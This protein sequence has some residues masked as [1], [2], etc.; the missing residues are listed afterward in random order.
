[1][2]F[3]L[4]IALV[5]VATGCGFTPGA[6]S[7][8]LPG[9]GGDVDADPTIDSTV[10]SADAPIFV[11]A[12][13]CLGGGLATVC[14]QPLPSQPLVLSGTIDTT[15]SP[16][17]AV[18]M[19]GG[20]ETCVLAGTTVQVAALT[21]YTATGTRPLVIVATDSVDIAG[22][23]DVAS[24]RGQPAGAGAST[25][26]CAAPAT[27]PKNDTGGAGGGAGGSFGDVGGNGGTGDIN[28]NG[29]SA[30]NA[31][32][33]TPAAAIKPT[34]IRAGCPG[35]AGGNGGGNVGSPGTGGGAVYLIA[36]MQISVGGGIVASGGGGGGGGFDE[37]GGG[38]GGSGG[39]VGLDAPSVMV[40]G[41]LA[42][43][44][45]GGGEGSGITASGNPGAN[46][47]ANASRA[48]GGIGGDSEGGN[49]G[50]GSGGASTTGSNG[51]NENGGGGGGGGGAGI[52]YVRGTLSGGGVTSPAPTVN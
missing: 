36:G 30:G 5:S 12:L 32:G 3:A 22:T 50:Q 51:G 18:M 33:G 43:T 17:C 37:S 21:T 13:A 44:G 11:D 14:L 16:D 19:L 47:T 52:I 46:G 24:R 34:L 42:S 9:D 35:G 4:R 38:G 31:P 6:T 49:G 2:R 39:L 20:I 1:V 26:V 29:G 27:T 45:G 23:L 41:T 10:I 28:N 40:E 25:A 15:T 8:A 48:S 7:Q